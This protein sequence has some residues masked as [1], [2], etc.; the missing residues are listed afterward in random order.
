[1]VSCWIQDNVHQSQVLD[2]TSQIAETSQLVLDVNPYKIH[3]RRAFYLRYTCMMK[4]LFKL[5]RTEVHRM[6]LAQCTEVPWCTVVLSCE[7][8]GNHKSL[9]TAKT[10]GTWDLSPVFISYKTLLLLLLLVW[11][12]QTP[13]WACVHVYPF[14]FTVQWFPVEGAGSSAV[15]ATERKR[16][17]LCFQRTHQMH[18]DL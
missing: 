2:I 11:L 9:I 1:M 10:C 6:I 4:S 16:V 14:P 15:H 13:L 17:G 5:I 3:T 7:T 12:Q 8:F 18:L